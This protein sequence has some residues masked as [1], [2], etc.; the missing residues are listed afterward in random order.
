MNTLS[1]ILQTQKG[2]DIK[3]LNR[4]L[5]KQFQNIKDKSL[6]IDTSGFLSLLNNAENILSQ[7]EQTLVEPSEDIVNVSDDDRLFDQ[8]YARLE[9]SRTALSNPEELARLA[10]N[11]HVEHVYLR[12]LNG[13]VPGGEPIDPGS[14]DPKCKDDIPLTTLTTETQRFREDNSHVL[15]EAGQR[16]L[17]VYLYTDAKRQQEVLLLTLQ[18][19]Q[20]MKLLYL[21]QE[22]E[23]LDSMLEQQDALVRGLSDWSY[24]LDQQTHEYVEMYEKMGALI[25]TQRR[26]SSFTV[27]DIQSLEQ[28]TYWS[29][30]V[31][32][33][34]LASCGVMVVVHNYSAVSRTAEQIDAGIGR[35]RTAIAT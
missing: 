14:G 24:Y 3:N 18:T 22:T 13:Q 21:Q 16:L 10:H 33:I 26:K 9:A 1:N 7:N 4:D 8:Y 25:S 19:E 6:N 5:R 29:Q 35:I 27:R 28:W 20:L 2:K 12:I 30:V 11:V 15:N 23:L 31:F 17:L 34:L 32:W